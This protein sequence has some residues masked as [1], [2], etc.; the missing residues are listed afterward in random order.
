MDEDTSSLLK[1]IVGAVIVVLLLGFLIDQADIHY[2]QATTG[3]R[4]NV[5]L[6]DQVNN[7][8]HVIE[9]NKEYF[10]EYNAIVAQEH[11]VVQAKQA[12]Q[13]FKDEHKGQALDYGSEQTEGQLSSTYQGELAAV[14]S[15]VQE[16]NTRSAQWSENVFKDSALPR[17]IDADSPPT[18]TLDY[19]Q[20]AP[21]NTLSPV[22]PITNVPNH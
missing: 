8:P 22:N 15:L 4:V 7:G 9:A 13:D 19:A 5:E 16:Y 20:Q 10:E 21:T 6:N 1:W 11:N 17:T 12:L 3:Q 14:Q 2:H 18:K